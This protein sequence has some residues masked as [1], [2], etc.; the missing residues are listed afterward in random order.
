[1]KTETPFAIRPL[2]AARAKAPLHSIALVDPGQSARL[3][4]EGTGPVP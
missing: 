4:K 2:P 1:M 3:L